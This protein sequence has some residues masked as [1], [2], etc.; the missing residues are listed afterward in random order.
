[1]PAENEVIETTQGEQGDG[2]EG[3][4]EESLN[5]LSTEGKGQGKPAPKVAKKD[6]S[7]EEILRSLS[8]D[9]SQI[10]EIEEDQSEE[11]EETETEVET[12]EVE[13]DE[14]LF[15]IIYK[16]QVEP[17]AKS[18]VIKLAQMGKDYTV[19]TQAL[20]N[21]RQ[22]FQADSLKQSQEIEALR[23]QVTQ[24]QQGF[25]QDK[26]HFDKL[27]FA[28][29]V[30][31]NAN[32][33]LY[34]EIDAAIAQVLN[35]YD[36]PVIRKQNDAIT[37]KQ[38]LLDDRLAEIEGSTIKQTFTNDLAKVKN[39]F[40]KMLEDNGI[41]PDWDGEVKKAY[42]DG[43]PTV[44]DA[45]FSVYGPQ[46]LALNDSKNKLSQVRKQT[47]R[48][49]AKPATRPGARQTAVPKN[50]KDMS[51]SAILNDSLKELGL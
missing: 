27:K 45:L 19:K 37:A 15:D 2:Y 5:E 36:N 18:E 6:V 30:L 43:A 34:K 24:E 13:S 14:E 8:K 38:K 40:G 9:K 39:D 33:D 48:M 29:G 25:T 10:E 28:F 21:E 11:V 51:Y 26:E 23:N 3:L 31:E 50:V 49:P 17:M 42:A 16:G 7:P 32:P 47:A 22:K 20:A 35:Q 1:M 44:K 4:I 41:F 12:D 46:I